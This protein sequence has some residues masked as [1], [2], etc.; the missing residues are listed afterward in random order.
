MAQPM[1]CRP[2]AGKLEA[3]PIGSE[4][5]FPFKNEIPLSYPQRLRQRGHGLAMRSYI[6]KGKLVYF[7]NSGI[8]P[9]SHVPAFG[10]TGTF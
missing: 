7:S 1:V 8:Y 9:R 10:R 2:K 3:A 6:G 5:A 4:K